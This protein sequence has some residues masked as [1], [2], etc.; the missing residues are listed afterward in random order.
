MWKSNAL[1]ERLGLD[2]PIIQAPM[3]GASTPAMAAAVANAGGMGSL[4]LAI[5][6]AETGGAQIEEF[7]KTS[8]GAFNANYF[9]HDDPGD[10]T[11][12]AEAMRARLKGWYDEAGLGA[13]P[14]PTIP[15]ATFGPDHLAVIERLRPTVV[16]FHFGLPDPELFQAV[17]D[18]GAF[19]LCSATTVAEAR[20]VAAGGV[21]AVIAQ[22]TEAGGHRGTFLGADISMQ[23]GLFALLPQ[24]V[25]A[26]DVPVI[27]AG[28]IS[29]GRGIAAA[30]LMGAQA[31][32]VGTAFLRTPEAS[33]H[34]AHRAAL[35]DARD[36][37]TR[38]TSLF[39]GKPARS[40][41]NAYL[42]EFADAE[43]LAAPY[44][45][46]LSLHGPLRSLPDE[47]QGEVI[48]LWAGQAAA[49][50]RDEPTAAVFERLIRET[51]AAFARFR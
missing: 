2:V 38:L 12:T 13:V 24:V 3:A 21:D 20:Q 10:V 31:A 18:T 19:T 32:Q 4:G 1:T 43:A 40:L 27:A 39:S 44:P 47:R 37:A 9:T 15:Y 42:D 11:G 49:L 22:G 41:R 23:P 7:R 5:L 25:D 14:Q 6:D 29:D 45:S 16:S 48:S 46:Q 8:N 51:D 50:A 26:V 35:A 28:G 36:D 17:K 33:L 34:P 30:L